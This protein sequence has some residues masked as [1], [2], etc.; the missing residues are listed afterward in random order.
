MHDPLKA[1]QEHREV[2]SDKWRTLERMSLAEFLYA[3]LIESDD[4]HTRLIDEKK[5]PWGK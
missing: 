3:V 2:M 1:A 4:F 5:L